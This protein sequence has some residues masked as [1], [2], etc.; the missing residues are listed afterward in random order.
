MLD[1]VRGAGCTNYVIIEW[2]LSPIYGLYTYKQ[3]YYDTCWI[4]FSLS[5]R[6]QSAISERQ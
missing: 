6:R 3:D 5:Y 1:A 2:N 4:I